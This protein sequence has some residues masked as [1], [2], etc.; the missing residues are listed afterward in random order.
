M[1][2]SVEGYSSFGVGKYLHAFTLFVTWD[3]WGITDY[4]DYCL[5]TGNCIGES[6]RGWLTD[7][8]DELE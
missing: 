6:F 5:C 2:T 8:L 4:C 3:G 7:W 1:S